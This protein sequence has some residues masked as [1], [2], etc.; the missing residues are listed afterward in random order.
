MVLYTYI[1]SSMY[2]TFF[3]MDI[4]YYNTKTHFL[5]AVCKTKD[6]N[7]KI[8]KLNKNQLDAHLF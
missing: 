8:I 1:R 4:V 3:I 5:I 2:H 7:Y 6:C